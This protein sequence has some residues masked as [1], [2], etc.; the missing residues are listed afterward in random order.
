MTEICVW[1]SEPLDPELAHGR[2]KGKLF[3]GRIWYLHLACIETL[4]RIGM[5]NPNHDVE[6]FEAKT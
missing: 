5:L 1:C 6:Y 4:Q 3:Q 2:I